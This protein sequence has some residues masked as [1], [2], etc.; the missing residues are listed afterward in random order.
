MRF[1]FCFWVALFDRSIHDHCGIAV[2]AAALAHQA[3]HQVLLQKGVCFLLFLESVFVVVVWRFLN[4]F[5]G[6][7][8][9][10]EPCFLFGFWVQVAILD[11]KL[12]V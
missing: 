6:I 10:E 3:F 5:W 12:S 9:W 11:E 8:R 2:F 4:L 7:W 1:Y